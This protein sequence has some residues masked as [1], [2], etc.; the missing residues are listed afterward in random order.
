MSRLQWDKI[1]ERFYETGVSNGVL[2]LPNSN[3]VYD[4]G[5]AWNGLTGVTESPSGAESNKQF[6]DNIP[7]LNLISAEELGGTIEAFTSPKEFDQC[8]GSAAPAPG[9]SVGQQTR[10][11]FGL[12]YQTLIGNDLEG[13]DHGYK[14]HVVYGAQASPSERA[15]ATVNDSPEAI[16]LSWEFQTTPAPIVPE[17]IVS[18]RALKPTSSLTFDS[19]DFTTAKMNELKDILWGTPSQDPRLPTPSE[20]ITLM[21][22]NL[23]EVTPAAPTFDD[24]DDELTI[25]ATAGVVYSINGVVVASG[26]SVLTEAVLVSAAPA[27]GYKFPGIVQT[28]WVFDPS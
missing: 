21:T 9:I 2:Y 20:L 24:V 6:A 12:S 15:Y 13:Q 1:G 22:S 4:T 17:I 14:I 10:R 28:Q 25:P 19:R 7:Y 16:T 5:Y 26:V 18:G 11:P 8:D 23:T 3:G 27:T